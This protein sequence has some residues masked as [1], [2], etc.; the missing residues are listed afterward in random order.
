MTRLRTAA[1]ALVLAVALAGAS[2]CNTVRGMGEDLKQV[3]RAIQNAV[4]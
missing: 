2:G 3:G 4:N 1:L